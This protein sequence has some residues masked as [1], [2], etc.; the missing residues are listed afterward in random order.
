M[1]H[2]SYA[3]FN[4]PLY[5]LHRIGVQLVPPLVPPTYTTAS[6]SSEAPSRPGNIT[7]PL[8]RHMITRC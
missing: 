2:Y 7:V 3:T 1:S 5:Y 8:V 6:E 4:P